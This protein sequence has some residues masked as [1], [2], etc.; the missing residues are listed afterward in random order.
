VINLLCLS[1]VLELFTLDSYL[2]QLIYTVVTCILV[3]C[4]TQVH[5]TFGD[6][7]SLS[8]TASD[9]DF[10]GPVPHLLCYLIQHVFSVH[11]TLL[12]ELY[13]HST[14]VR[15][16]GTVFRPCCVQSSQVR[17][18]H[19]R[20]SGLGILL[21]QVKLGSTRARKTSFVPQAFVSA[22]CCPQHAYATLLP[23]LLSGIALF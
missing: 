21:Y 4:I 13:L 7:V 2:H 10:T 5:P 1:L 6:T 22:P 9:R 3:V 23:Y 14:C 16:D 15:P 8:P 11:C 18:I 19:P 12:V 17:G 20:Q